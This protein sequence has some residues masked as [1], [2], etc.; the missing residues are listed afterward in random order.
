MGCGKSVVS[1][2]LRK[3]SY[4]VLDTDSIV[5]EY[6]K[7]EHIKNL[8]R[9]Q[10]GDKAVNETDVDFNFLK[11]NLFKQENTEKRR[12]IETALISTFY[13]KLLFDHKLNSYPVV[14]VEAALTESLSELID[15]LHITDI[16][17]VECDENI[18][19]NR[20]I[21]RGMSEHDIKLRSA[22]QKWPN[23]GSSCKFYN[24]NNNGKLSELFCAVND[25]LAGDMFSKE[26]K[27]AIFK[28]YLDDAPAYCKENTWCYAFYNGRGCASC[29]FPCDRQEKSFVETMKSWLDEHGSV[30][31][32]K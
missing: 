16:I 15:E 14:F 2:L 18:R 7:K 3:K 21:K 29:P 12:I 26:E 6:Y 9:T 4:T 19:Y 23:T 24:L 25:M 28:K 5:K 31:L 17:R 11:E 30:F 1:D 10:F 13:V 20:L 22:L 8:V 32:K 27:Y